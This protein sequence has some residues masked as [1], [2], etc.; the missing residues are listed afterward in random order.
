MHSKL[1][2]LALLG[3]LLL[4]ACTKDPATT[5]G[6]T[7][8]KVRAEGK[9]KTAIGNGIGIDEFPIVLYKRPYKDVADSTKKAIQLTELAYWMVADK[10]RTHDPAKKIEANREVEHSIFEVNDKVEGLYKDAIARQ[11]D[12]PLNYA[13][14]ALYLKPR[15]RHKNGNE[16]VNCENEALA[17]LD[18]AIELWPDE[19]VFYL[20]KVFVYTEPH[21][22]HDWYRGSAMEELGI[23]EQMDQI[24]DAFHKAEQFY[25]ANAYINYYH[26]ITKYQFTDPARLNEI[27]EDLLREIRAGNLK[28][29]NYFYF[30]PP[31]P[32]YTAEAQR[33]RLFGTETE[34]KYVDQWLFWGNWNITAANDLL[35]ALSADLSWPRDKQT[36]A[37]LMYFAYRLGNT[38]PYDRSFF[39][40]QQILLDKL[41]ARKDLAE[42]DRVQLMTAARYL[43]EI[44]REQAERLYQKKAIVDPTMLDVAGI[45]QVESGISRQLNV[46]ENLQG[47]QARYLEHFGQLFGIKFP[48]AKD[49]K[50]W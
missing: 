47:P 5:A 34:P 27:R 20:L 15:K 10:H 36:V 44:Y 29:D 9:S 40:W 19:S 49:P 12:N 23:A 32:F 46:E 50:D 21:R 43:G 17:Q 8:S 42:K 25:P 4:S 30:P 16:F 38:K 26:A 3:V 11:P 41:L 39:A 48:L 14:Y 22:C 24:E 35:E 18:K 31:L 6:G 1:A 2:A 28:H 37:D 7:G 45:S 33:P 13:A